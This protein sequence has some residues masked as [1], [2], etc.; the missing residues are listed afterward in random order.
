MQTKDELIEE[1]TKT[2]ISRAFWRTLGIALVWAASLVLITLWLNGT[3]VTNDTDPFITTED[4]EDVVVI[5]GD[6]YLSTLII[7]ETPTTVFPPTTTTMP[8]TPVVH[9]ALSAIPDS[10]SAP[11][12]GVTLIATLSGSATGEVW[13][14][15]ECDTGVTF[16]KRINRDS[17]TVVELCAYPSP[18]TYTPQV[19]VTRQGVTVVDILSILVTE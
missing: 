13:Y 8:S 15:F 10:G 1:L 5:I 2:R 9:V 7:I 19:T 17:Y 16:E 4:T 14:S 18:G 3:F 6:T 12:N 11:L